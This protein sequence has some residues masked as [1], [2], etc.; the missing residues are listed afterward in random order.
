MTLR[1]FSC[2]I[3]GLFFLCQDERIKVREGGCLFMSCAMPRT[4]LT[5]LDA[6]N[7]ARLFAKVDLG[8]EP[9][10]NIFY[11]VAFAL[12]LALSFFKRTTFE[13]ILFMAVDDFDLFATT[14]VVLLLLSKMLARRIRFSGLVVASIMVVVGFVSW[15]ES[16]EG[17]LFWLFLFV[18][19]GEGVSLRRIA[20]IVFAVNL[21][22]MTLT[23]VCAQMG[24]ID[25]VVMFRIE[26]EIR[27]SM[28]F[29]HPN[30]FG[31]S[32]LAVCL[33]LS[34]LR[35][36]KNPV[37][38][39]I[40]SIF[41]AVLSMVLAD[42]RTPAILV[43][44]QAFLLALFYMVRG[45]RGRRALRVSLLVTA[46]AALLLSLYF[47]LFYN[48]SNTVHHALDSFVNG[49][50]SLS[51]AY[52][53]LSSFSLFGNDYSSY[54]PI[55]WDMNGVT[56]QFVV[57]NAF[58]HI[59][60]RFGVV[61]GVLFAFGYAS[62]LIAAGRDKRDD[63]SFGLAVMALYSIEETAGAM[64]DINFFLVAAAGL[65]VYK[66]GEHGLGSVLKPVRWNDRES[67]LSKV[68]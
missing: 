65:V 14:V 31:A 54:S 5:T 28:G 58:C 66:S 49:R 56:N 32:L 8:K 48:P 45:E 64:V 29:V 22:L 38:S 26:G 17:W 57:D 37:P 13:C 44:L 61:A 15:R 16:G 42:S 2:L 1:V 52:Y 41:A 51:N 53:E 40:V 23:V 20:F 34:V 68:V 63:L 36:G 6:S 19:C 59:V 62:L 55:Y 30:S 3:V 7:S 11:Y 46:G 67:S 12:Y 27:Y 39:I 60:L 47:L 43:I 33:S 10:A 50:F 25:N 35:F 18:A 24:M 4:T 9:I 21:S